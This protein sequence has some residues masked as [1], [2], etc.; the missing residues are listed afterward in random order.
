M[1]LSTKQGMPIITYQLNPNI[2]LGSK[3]F[4]QTPAP[5]QDNARKVRRVM[6]IDGSASRLLCNRT[7]PGLV[8]EMPL[9]VEA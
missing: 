1:F 6:R 3:T 8:F 9:V 2:T 7:L 4:E 5:L